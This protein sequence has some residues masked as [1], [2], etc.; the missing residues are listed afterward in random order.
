MD[1]WIGGFEL[2]FLEE[3]P[4]TKGGILVWCDRKIFHFSESSISPN[5]RSSIHLFLQIILVLS[6]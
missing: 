2:K 6:L 3:H 4:F 5:V 1:R